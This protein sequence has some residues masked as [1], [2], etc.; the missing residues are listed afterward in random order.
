MRLFRFGPAGAE[1]PGV[2]MGDQRVDASAFGRDWNEEFFSGDGLARLGAWAA[3]EGSRAPRVPPDT[4]LGPPVARPSKIVCI[5]LNYRDHA[6]ET[7][8][9]IP[10]EPII[11]LK[12]TSALA[13]PDDNV[14]R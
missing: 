4:R 10:A 1:K 8:A 7:G 3:A 5:G 12:A 13:G 6:H 14:P 9:A 11:F 2:M